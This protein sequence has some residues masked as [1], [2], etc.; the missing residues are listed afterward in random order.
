MTLSRSVA[1]VAILFVARIAIGADGP[2]S[3]I[4]AKKRVVQLVEQAKKFGEAEYTIQT[5]NQMRFAMNDAGNAADQQST[6]ASELNDVYAKLKSK[7]VALEK[8]TVTVSRGPTFGLSTS[9]FATNP[10]GLA[11]NVA[12]MWASSEP[13]DRFDVYRAAAEAGPFKKINACTGLSYNDYDLTD[14]TYFYRV[15]GYRGG[16]KYSSNIASTSTLKLPAGLATFSNQQANDQ[17]LPDQPL[18]VGDT[19]YSF[20]TVR[21]GKALKHVLMKSSK[22]GKRWTDGVPVMDVNSHPDLA[23]FKFEAGRIFYDKVNDQIVWWCHYELS[24]PHYGSGKAMVATAKPGQPFKVHHIYRPLGVE[25]RDMTIFVDDD[26]KAYLVAASN[27]P[28]Q[29]ANATMYIFRLN[30]TCDDVVE[31]VA[32][33]LEDGYREA[34][35]IFREGGYYY[36]LFSQAAGWYPSRGGYLSARSLAGPWSEARSIGNPSTFSSQSGGI[37][38]FGTGGKFIPVMMGNRWIRGEG[39]SRTSALPIHFAE[40]FAFYDYAPAL[41]HDA[42]QNVLVPLHMGRLLSQGRPAQASIPGKPGNEIAKAFDGDYN[43]LFQSDK[44]DW[45]FS[46]TTDLGAKATVRNV[47]ISWYIHKG[48]EAFYT[49]TIEGS[50]DGK[51]WSTLIDRTHIEDTVVSKTYGFTSD[52]L[53]ER[54]IARFVKIDVRGAHLHNNSSN[55]YPPSIYEVKVFGDR[56]DA[57]NAE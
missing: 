56:V 46:I 49:Y 50:L 21:E 39:T 29:G 32:K 18:K 11:N 48:S 35:H 45:P 34:P 12:L 51:R 4:E 16:H 31:V 7:V 25:V 3:S 14:G 44:K 38:E 55:W 28:G 15:D 40:G 37:I 54:S 19:Q 27:L 17:A 52:I 43:T 26:Q 57:A 33:V 24:G 20:E 8:R 41:L 22:D 9:V 6:S 42:A 2:T 10:S 1:C 36:L 23:D 30:D 47:Q 53:P 13:C 5:W